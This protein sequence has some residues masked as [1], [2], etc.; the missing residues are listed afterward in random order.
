[1]EKMFVL[2][3]ISERKERTIQRQDGQTKVLKWYDV[4]M[5]NGLDTVMG[6]TS[7]SVTN[8]IDATDENAKL[9]MEVGKCYMCRVNLN[10]VEYEKDG[11]KSAFLKATFHQIA[12]I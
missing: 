6:E 11:K 1:M 3:S 7:E 2:K 5:S 12:L 10:V 9:L 8:Q 4:V